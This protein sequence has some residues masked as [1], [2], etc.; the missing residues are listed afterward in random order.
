MNSGLCMQEQ[1]MDIVLRV[2]EPDGVVPSRI[3]NRAQLLESSDQGIA[4]SP[5]SYALHP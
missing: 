1:D 4:L 5:M 3:D 2:G